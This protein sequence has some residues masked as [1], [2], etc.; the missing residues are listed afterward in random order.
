VEKSPGVV[1][2]RAWRLDS[3]GARESVGNVLL[4]LQP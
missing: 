3:T 2:A 1:T 4:A